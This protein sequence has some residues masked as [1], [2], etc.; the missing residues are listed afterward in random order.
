MVLARAERMRRPPVHE[1]GGEQEIRFT[2]GRDGVRL[3]YA[4]H[5]KG[6]PVIVVSC[7]LSHLQHDWRS[8]VWRHILEDLGEIATLVR[9]DKRGFGMSDWNVS[10]FSLEARLSDLETLINA[11]GF[12]RFAL[13]GMSGGSSVA[14]AYAARHADRVTRLILYGTV[15]GRPVM[16]DD[17]GWA[18]EETG[19]A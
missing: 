5:G 15:C 1:A 8:P 6:P 3:A 16:Y 9:Y 10:D 14:M 18:E 19:G 12:D 11:L 17:T 4:I 7:R 2:A 13:L